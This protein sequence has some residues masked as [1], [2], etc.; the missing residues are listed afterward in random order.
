MLAGEVQSDRRPAGL[1]QHRR[2]LRRGLHEVESFDAV[3]LSFVVDVV[4]L[5]WIGVDAAR[6]VV[7]HGALIPGAFPEFVDDVDILVGPLV[8]FLVGKV[9]R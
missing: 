8:A 2:A 9:A 3:A 4:D 6:R 7:D 5:R 1:R